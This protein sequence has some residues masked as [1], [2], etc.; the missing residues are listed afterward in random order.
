MLDGCFNTWDWA[1]DGL[2]LLTSR[3]GQAEAV[4]LRKISTGARRMVLSHPGSNF[5]AARLSPDGRWIA[6]AAGATGAETRVFVAPVRGSATPER[7]WIVVSPEGGDPAW[8]PDG[9]VLYFRSRR[10]ANLCIWAQKLGPGK[11]PAGEPAAILHLHSAALG[12]GFLKPT[13][14][15]I[16]VTKDRLTLNLGRTSGTLWTMML[17]RTASPRSQ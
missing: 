14:F 1:P 10:D 5:F 16:A 9:N 11:T 4:D 8:S 7:E 12:I 15:S 13:E 2:S 3:S 17:P 6:F